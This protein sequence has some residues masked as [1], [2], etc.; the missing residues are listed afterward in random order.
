MQ[1]LLTW[2]G[3]NMTKFQFWDFKQDGPDLVA[4]SQAVDFNSKKR[5]LSHH[6]IK[7][8]KASNDPTRRYTKLHDPSKTGSTVVSRNCVGS[9]KS[10]LFVPFRHLN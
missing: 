2:I 9:I 7:N 4:I 10:N 5:P 6:S 1:K 8:R 3:E